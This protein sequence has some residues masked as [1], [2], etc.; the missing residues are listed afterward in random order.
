[1][2]ELTVARKY[3]EDGISSETVAYP[4]IVEVDS[5]R[6]SFSPAE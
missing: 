6:E 5:K 1:M 3:L 2:E 4:D